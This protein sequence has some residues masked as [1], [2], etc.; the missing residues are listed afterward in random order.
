MTVG[1]DCVDDASVVA[2][3]AAGAGVI[4]AAGDVS[5]TDVFGADGS[6]RGVGVGVGVDVGCGAAGDAG[7]GCVWSCV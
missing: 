7:V 1:G 3:A 5:A 4:V 6:A 2:G